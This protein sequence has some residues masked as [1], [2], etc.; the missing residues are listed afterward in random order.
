[1][2]AN[3]PLLLIIDYNLAR[4]SDVAHIASYA[5]QRYGAEIALIRANPT[6]RDSLLCEYLIDLDPLAPDFV[7]QA[8]YYLKSWRERLRAGLVFSDNAVQSGA[9]LLER[10]GLLVDSAALAANAYSKRDYRV[11]EARVRDLLEAQG[12]LVPDCVEVH[13]VDDLGRFA[14]AHEG[15]FV[16]KPSCEGNNRGVVLVEPG[17]SLDA[18]FAAVAPY[19][20]RGAICESFI[21]FPREFSFDG[22]GATHFI[23]EKVSAQGRYPVEVAQILP[24]RLTAAEQATLTRAG[25]IANLL[26]GQLRGPF[27]NEIKL[28]D[29]GLHAAV[30]EPNRRPAG[31]KIWTI[32]REVYEVDFYALWV[33]AAFGVVHEPAL[34][35]GNRQA[36]TVM[37]G[38]PADG[39]FTAPGV[40]EGVELFD[41][42]LARAAALL[43]TGAL[44]R[45]EFGWLAQTARF[46]P[47]VP[48]DNA[49]FAAQACFALESDVH[50]MRGVVATVRAVWLSV[51]A[52]ARHI[53]EPVSA[54]TSL[55][56]A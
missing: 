41:R 10:L 25:R 28:D 14:G 44:R 43:G 3:R 2:N 56:I 32:A 36:A 13:N 8:L 23:T 15:G 27:H 34:A 48:R 5:R 30:V 40:D 33:D 12:M 17:D 35:S 21:S 7:D 9:A 39:Q 46:I 51:L 6:E 26:V 49:D 38:V 16:V 20:E 50:D 1:M 42:T 37:L 54:A 11:S 19:L 24:A 29:T 52:E 53:F 4:V 55:A 31:M 47:A 22:V 45:L 18:A